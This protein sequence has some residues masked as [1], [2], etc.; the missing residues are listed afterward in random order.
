MKCSKRGGGKQEKKP[1]RPD[2]LKEFLKGKVITLDCGHKFT[3]HHL[4]NTMI[5]TCDGKTQCHNCFY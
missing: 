1:C 3:L 4:S 2:E 5:M